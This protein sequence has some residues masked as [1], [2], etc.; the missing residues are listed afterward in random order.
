MLLE[1]V[2]IVYIAAVAALF[3]LLLLLK[4]IHVSCPFE[5]CETSDNSQ[6]AFIKFS[7][8]VQLNAVDCV[9]SVRGL[10]LCWCSINGVALAF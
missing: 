2:D 10:L 9:V 6:L 4:G 5:S 1:L 8:H 3:L 7:M